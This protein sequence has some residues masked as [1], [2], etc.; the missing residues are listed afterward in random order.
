MVQQDKDGA[1]WRSKGEAF[2]PK[3]TAAVKHGGGGGSITLWA[4]VLVH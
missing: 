2:N 3:S 4:V 1:V